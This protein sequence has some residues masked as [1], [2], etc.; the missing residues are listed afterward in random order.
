MRISDEFIGKFRNMYQT[1]LMHAHIDK[2]TEVSHVSDYTF[3]LHAFRQLRNFSNVITEF[4]SAE[5]WT[6]VTARFFQ[7]SQYVLNRRQT[8]FL[9]CKFF[10]I[11]LANDFSI[12]ND[13]FY[14]SEE[15]RVGKECVS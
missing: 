12:T 5:F 10:C 11:H 4:S 8:K 13:V 2:C 9:V 7:F 15:R 14:R 3:Q 1:I 6:R